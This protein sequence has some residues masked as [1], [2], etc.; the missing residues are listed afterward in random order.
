MDFTNYQNHIVQS[1]HYKCIHNHG[2]YVNAFAIFYLTDVNIEKDGG[3]LILHDPSFSGLENFH[4]NKVF[5]ISPKKNRMV[6]CPN[7]I[8]HEVARYNGENERLCVIINLTSCP[9][10]ELNS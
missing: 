3:E 1:F 2:S 10:G 4:E 8:W 7:H 9:R 5:K 6:I